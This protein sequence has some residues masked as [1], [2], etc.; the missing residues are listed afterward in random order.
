LVK[1]AGVPV[2]RFHNMRHTSAKL[3]L[4]AGENVKVVSERLGHAKMRITLDTYAHVLPTMQK[5]PA[6]RLQKLLG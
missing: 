1:A 4:L 5:R 6:D 3:L 2:I